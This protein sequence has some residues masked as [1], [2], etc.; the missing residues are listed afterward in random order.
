MFPQAI[1]FICAHLIFTYEYLYQE[2][3]RISQA[4][5]GSFTLAAESYNVLKKNNNTSDIINNSANGNNTAAFSKAKQ[6]INSSGVR[7]ICT[8]LIN[9]AHASLR[10]PAMAC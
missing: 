10:R 5:N 7:H 1:I 9:S 4:S 2:I 6:V 8:R 3:E